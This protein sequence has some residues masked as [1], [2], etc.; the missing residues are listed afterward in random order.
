MT[1]RVLIV[2]LL[3]TV[4]GAGCARRHPIYNVSG[5]RLA[6][7]PGTPSP[8]IGQVSKAI[9]AAGKKLGWQIEEVRPGE[10]TGTLHLRSHVA[11]VSIVHDTST[12]SINFK[13]STNL[14]HDGDRIHKNYNKWIRRLERQIQAE[15]ASTPSAR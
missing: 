2:L 15:I 1:R 12:F 8:A 3:G 11:V 7:A 6:Q 5:A 13:D 9:W 10:L 14:L 4:V